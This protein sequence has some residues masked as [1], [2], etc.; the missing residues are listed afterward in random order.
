MATTPSHEANPGPDDDDRSAVPEGAATA[1]DAAA[2]IESGPAPGS[3][4]DSPDQPEAQPEPQAD[5]DEEPLALQAVALTAGDSDPLEVSARSGEL[6]LWRGDDGLGTAE[7]TL[8][9]SGRF[10]PVTGQVRL[11]TRD[12]DPAVLRREVVVA[13]VLDAV[14]AEP[15]LRV[16]EYLHSCLVLHGRRHN[17]LSPRQA[18]AEVGYDGDD[19]TAMED[20]PPADAVRVAVA[21]ALLARPVAVTVDRVDRGIADDD[22]AALSADLR[23]AAELSGVAIVAS[24]VRHPKEQR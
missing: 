10:R 17:R 5:P 19:H 24:A 14:E 7:L 16:K 3:A 15:R 20:L 22:W 2:D 11:L 4:V 23:R 18:L 12:A 13:R 21:G 9:L 6:T 8:A 1:G